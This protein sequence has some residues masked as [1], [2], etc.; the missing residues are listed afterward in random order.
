MTAH[1]LSLSLLAETFAICRCDAGAPI[2]GWATAGEH[3]SITR[4]P[5]ELSVVCPQI[6]VPDDVSCEGGWRCL[7]VAGTLDFA[8][9]GILASLA[10]PLAQVGI[11]IVALSTYATDYLLIK[12]HNLARAIAV[13]S[14]SGHQ[15]QS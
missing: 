10:M 11:S 2:P 3:W 4:T 6:H 12:E 1:R 9:T 7:R 5:D 14:E 15:I 13:L 8:L